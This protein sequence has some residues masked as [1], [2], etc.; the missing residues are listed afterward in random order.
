VL[1]HSF[2]SGYVL[3]KRRQLSNA[4][5]NCLWK[6]PLHAFRLMKVTRRMA[7]RGQCGVNALEFDLLIEKFQEIRFI[8]QLP[9]PSLFAIAR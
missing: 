7:E 8:T 1:C 2:V 9:V 3:T 6:R 5:V 4:C